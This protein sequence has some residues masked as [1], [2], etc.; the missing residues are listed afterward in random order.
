MFVDNVAT[1]SS[2]DHT[3][4][5][6]TVKFLPPN[7]TSKLQPLDAGIIKTFKSLH[8]KRLV[9]HILLHMDEIN[10]ASDMAK[11]VNLLDTIQWC[12]LSWEGVDPCVIQKCFAK[13]GFQ[14]QMEVQDITL[15]EEEVTDPEIARRRKH[16]A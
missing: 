15:P 5:Q 1:H 10:T 12:K 9:R 11:I 7:T 2:R 14:N 4:I 13:C 8:R 6:V 16:T 3:L